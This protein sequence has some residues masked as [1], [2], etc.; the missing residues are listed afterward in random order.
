MRLSRLRFLRFA[1][2]G[3]ATPLVSGLAWAQAWPTRPI[4]AIVPYAPGT[5]IDIVGRLVLNELSTQLG[6]SIV[7]ENR[8]GAS[9]T[10]GAAM[11]AKAAADGYTM[12]VDTS[13]R[14]IVP[15]TMS[16]LP[17]DLV[18]DFS[19]VIPLATTPLVLVVA[20][21]KGIKTVDDLAAAAKAKPGSFNFASPGTGSTIYLATERLCLAAGFK[22]VQVP[23]RGGGFGA[24][25][26]S[27]RIDFAY[28]P[29]GS[30]I[31]LVQ[32]GQLL[33]L[34]VASRKR[35]AILPD[36]PTTLEAGYPNA[37][38]AL[39][40]GMFVPAKTSRDI[41]D[42]LSQETSKVIRTP[43]MQERFARIGAEAMIMTPAAFD[44]MVREEFVANAALVKSM[45]LTPN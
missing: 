37:D 42:N 17:Y 16:N 33:A 22:A 38:F 23:F 32:G 24:D 25:L 1:S 30:V 26:I 20:P 3:L 10:I 5:G 11:V 18:Q 43:S 7:V 28:S 2:A 36:V 12:L 15:A 39:W 34:A 40:F 44:A 19:S 45:G 41:V 8:P 14:T 27:G 21:S 4:R 31:D 9:A 6:Q 35:A 13:S 29:I